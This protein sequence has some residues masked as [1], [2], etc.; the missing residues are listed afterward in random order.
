[1]AAVLFAPFPGA[2][3]FDVASLSHEIVPG[4]ELDLTGV[5][6]DEIRATAHTTTLK[7]AVPVFLGGRGTVLVNFLTLRSLSQSYEVPPTAGDVFR[8]D[9]LFTVK[10]GLVL[11]RELSERWSVAV[12]GQP[13]ILSDFQDVGGDH[14]S[15]RAGFL[16]ERVVSPRFTWAFGAGYSDDYGEAQALPVVRIDWRPD[17]RW[18]IRLDAPQAAEIWWGPGDRWRLGA[19]GRATGGHF[20]VG[21]EYV[22]RDG[23][24][25]KDGR[26]KYSIVN[27][28]PAA[29]A[30]L[31]G[32]LVLTL[33]AGWSVYRRYEVFDRDDRALLDSRFESSLFV[34]TTLGVEVGSE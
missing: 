28:G 8:P 25:T 13:A 30:R 27:V 23:R 11:R 12:L 32:P 22:F 18:R 19:A 15:L 10:Y 14:F 4:A 17:R 29:A 5:E 21:E 20:R 16:F 6:E 1:V 2:R 24:S 26:V 31:G 34:K 9:D 33:N 7:L 3:A